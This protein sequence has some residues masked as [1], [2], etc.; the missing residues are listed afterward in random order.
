MQNDVGLWVQVVACVGEEW[1]V[2]AKG[3]AEARGK[4]AR[5]ARSGSSSAEPVHRAAKEEAEVERWVD[6]FIGPHPVTGKVD[7]W[8]IDR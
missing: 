7:H 8:F 1:A 6:K 4:R 5:P 3:Y 2:V